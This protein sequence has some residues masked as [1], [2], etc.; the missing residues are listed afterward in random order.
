MVA[1]GVFPGEH[2]ESPA[3]VIERLERELDQTAS[4]AR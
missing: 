2:A 4:R 3:P 1:L